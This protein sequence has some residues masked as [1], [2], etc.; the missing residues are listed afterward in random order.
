MVATAASVAA[1]LPWKQ[2]IASLPTVVAT[3][4]RLW[5]GWRATPKPK[6]IDT[7]A[8]LETQVLDLSQRVEALE[9]NE[10]SQSE[11]VSQIAEQLQGVAAGLREESARVGRLVIATS[12]LAVALLALSA[13]V[14]AAIVLR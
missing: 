6:P 9:G 12:V 14:L 10:K 7:S 13:V 11:V 2:I 1:K 8:S 3:A 4:Q 5:H